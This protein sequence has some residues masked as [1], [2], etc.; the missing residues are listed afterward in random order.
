MN[1]IHFTDTREARGGEVLSASL[2]WAMTTPTTTFTLQMAQ[3]PTKR[4]GVV[5][6]GQPINLGALRPHPAQ[7]ISPTATQERRTLSLSPWKD[8]LF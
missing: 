7:Q 3:R 5:G 4:K 1:S 8:G 6:L 2:R